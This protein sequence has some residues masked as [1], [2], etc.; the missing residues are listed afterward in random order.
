[1]QISLWMTVS[2]RIVN[3]MSVSGPIIVLSSSPP[4]IFA[5]SPTP[6]EFF[7]SSPSLP[8]PSEI[9][10]SQRYNGSQHLRSPQIGQKVARKTAAL[11]S[12]REGFRASSKSADPLSLHETG[13]KEN[14]PIARQARG[15]K[16]TKAAGQIRR[17]VTKHCEKNESHAVKISG[18]QLES[19]NLG[20]DTVDRPSG[21]RRGSDVDLSPLLL[22]RAPSRRMDWTPPPSPSRRTSPDRKRA[23]AEPGPLQSF[24][25][26]V[27][28]ESARGKSTSQPTESAFR[29]KRRKL[30]VMETGS[31][32]AGS[33]GSFKSTKVATGPGKSKAAKKY[34]TITGL[35]TSRY[36]LAPEAPSPIMQFLSATQERALGD[37]A[38]LVP[39]TTVR[40]KT[41]KKAR[42]TKKAVSKPKLL[43]PRSALRIF[44][45][46]EALF[47]SASQ[48]AREE[49]PTLTK[50]IMQALKESENMS[51]SLAPVSSQIT[52]P[53]SEPSETPKK[54]EQQGIFQF[55]KARNLWSA[56]GR[57]EDNAL[58]QVDTLDMFD[59]PGIRNAFAGKDVLLEPAA[60]KR[61]SLSPEKTCGPP[62]NKLSTRHHEEH[63]SLEKA[64]LGTTISPHPNI[65]NI[66][67]ASSSLES[68]T[69]CAA[70]R[71]RNLP[72][73]RGLHTLNKS[74]GTD[75]MSGNTSKSPASAAQASVLKP[76]KPPYKGFTD[77]QLAS[78][79]KAYGFKPIKK[80]DKMI[81]LLDRCWDNKYAEA[82]QQDQ[83]HTSPDNE[84]SNITHDDILTKV[85]DIAARPTPK[86]KKPRKSTKDP[87]DPKEPVKEK[88]AG[89][90]AGDRIVKGRKKKAETMTGAEK[91]AE[92][93][94]STCVNS[95]PRTKSSKA[96]KPRED[97][98]DI[99]V[100]HDREIITKPCLEIL[101][102][103][104]EGPEVPPTQQ[105]A[106]TLDSTSRSADQNHSHYQHPNLTASAT[107]SQSQTTPVISKLIH[108]A[109][110]SQPHSISSQKSPTFHQQILMYTPLV[111]EDLTRWLNTDGLGRVSYDGEVRATEVRDWCESRGVCCFWAEGGRRQER[112]KKAIRGREDI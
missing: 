38:D 112:K 52:I 15:L 10:A 69:T 12:T 96:S 44:D 74:A 43:S 76:G 35:A 24:H 73:V 26:Q 21:S 80:R 67:L 13:S 7:S 79:I 99:L 51:S 42:V 63:F 53:T 78:Q 66:A 3:S 28:S 88:Q 87:K 94:I 55:A 2:K 11:H 81:E 49:S 101:A 14:L 23:S 89:K 20:D 61:D 29:A 22:D 107:S 18:R 16:S 71:S 75:Q 41:V 30:E 93:A 45:D 58:L 97:G 85:H 62:T 72:L 110:V 31:M 59:S 64:P 19:S 36:E 103:R 108:K 27:T 54:N 90:A 39:D 33:G 86:T 109:I 5:R 47:G 91:T 60:P 34:T 46:Q 32:M 98:K 92:A 102:T 100:N 105:L 82:E 104:L 25:Y 57:D 68:K 4:R 83:R 50:D 95:L 8:S 65:S 77:S 106:V 40:K 70:S 84:S 9:F 37:D 1:M 56:A 6:A 111:I 17:A 48:L